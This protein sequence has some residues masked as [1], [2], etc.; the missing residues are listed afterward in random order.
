M[1]FDLLCALLGF[2]NRN[3]FIQGL[4]SEPPQYAHG[5]KTML[6]YCIEF[7]TR[8]DADKTEYKL[9]ISLRLNEISV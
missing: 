7:T 5:H 9:Q 4:G 8:Q 2:Y 3:G 6:N 1:I